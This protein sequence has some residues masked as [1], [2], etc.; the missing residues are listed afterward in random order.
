MLES[1]KIPSHMNQIWSMGFMLGRLADGCGIRVLNVSDDFDRGVLGTEVT[2][3]QGALTLK[4]IRDIVRSVVAARVAYGDRN[5]HYLDGLELF[6]EA[7]AADL[8]DDLHPNEAGYY[9]M[10]ERFAQLAFTDGPFRP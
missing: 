4:Q 2:E 10:G 5:L 9:R 3:A 7:D 1:L 6:G 8:P